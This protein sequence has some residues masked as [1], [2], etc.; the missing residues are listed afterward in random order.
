MS[1]STRFLLFATVF[2]LFALGTYLHSYADSNSVTVKVNHTEKNWNDWVCK[3]LETD[4][5]YLFH[6]NRINQYHLPNDTIDR[7]EGEDQSWL[8]AV[9]RN[10]EQ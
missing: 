3:S 8:D 6:P 9:Q 5:N 2:A 10:Q 1:S 4:W 7:S